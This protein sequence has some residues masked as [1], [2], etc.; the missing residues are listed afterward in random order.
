MA[1][2]AVAL[3]ATP[4]TNGLTD[5]WSQFYLLDGGERLGRTFTDF[6]RR[7]FDENRF[8]HEVRPLPGAP[9]EIHER[10]ADITL[11]LSADDYLD[12]PDLI[13]RDVVVDL[14]P[15]ARKQ[16]CKLEREFLI[17]LDEEGANVVAGSAAVLANKLRQVCQGSI[18]DAERDVHSLHT[19]KLDAF[20]DLLGEINDNV[21]LA[22]SF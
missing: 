5:L 17:A 1:D 19:A 13:V 9:N 10:V 22:Y 14:P 11:R 6:K 20:D 2:H 18:Y 7:W 8:T 21:L 12:M 3:T 15:V 16:Y 4:A